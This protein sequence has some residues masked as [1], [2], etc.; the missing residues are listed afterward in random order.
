M[1]THPTHEAL[2][3]L[4]LDGMAEAFAELVTQ[5]RGRSLDPVAWIGLM[6]DREQARRGTRRF[7][8]RPAPPTCAT[9]TPAWKTWITGRRAASTER[10]SRA[11]GTP[12]GLTGTARS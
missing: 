2:S 9:A 5:D 3:A 7:Q 12:S 6:L 8:S 11:S 4:K 10:C 1:L